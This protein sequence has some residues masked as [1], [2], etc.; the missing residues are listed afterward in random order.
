MKKGERI[1]EIRHG[2]APIAK[3]STGCSD[4]WRRHSVCS[5]C[6]LQMQQ[7]MKTPLESVL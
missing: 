1:P 2:T 7:G 5:F 6:I 3:S 4:C